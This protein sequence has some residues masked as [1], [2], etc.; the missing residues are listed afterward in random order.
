MPAGIM[1]RKHHEFM[2]LEQGRRSVY[3]YSKL[4]N[5]LAQYVPEQVNTDTKKKACFMTGLSTMLKERLALNT[6]RTFL[7]FVSNAT[8]ADDAIHAHKEGKK[9][10][11]MAALSRSAPPKYRVAYAP[12]NN[13]PPHSQQ[14]QHWTSHPSQQQQ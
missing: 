6:A 7:E 12:R 5:H 13:P 10:K 2:D 11:A 14:H 3:D 8:I 1:L 9:R 4:F